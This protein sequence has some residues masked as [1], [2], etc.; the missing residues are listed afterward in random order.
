MMDNRKE[1]P[2]LVVNRTEKTHKKPGKTM[3]NPQK[4]L[5]GSLFCG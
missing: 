3:Q 1:G 5:H 2:G 4:R